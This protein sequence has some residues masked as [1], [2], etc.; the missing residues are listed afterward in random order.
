LGSS[1]V[2]PSVVDIQVEVIAVVE[3]EMI[4]VQGSKP[5]AVVVGTHL[6]FCIDSC[7]LDSPESL[8]YRS[9]LIDQIHLD[10]RD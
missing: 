6:W 2:E 3:L 5:L 9:T 1:F 10:Q 7:C 4:G 8:G